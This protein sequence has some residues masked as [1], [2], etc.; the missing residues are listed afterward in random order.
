MPWQTPT[1]AAVRQQ[2][3]DYIVGRLGAPL[4]PNSA[5]RVLADA[6]GG[7]AHLALQY[8]DYLSLQLLPDTAET[9]FLDKWANIFLVNADGSRGRKQG[10]FAS[11]PL[12]RVQ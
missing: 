6:N 7:N 10:T 1:L 3:R 4:V 2:A 5:G 11:G 12:P 8:I 9:V